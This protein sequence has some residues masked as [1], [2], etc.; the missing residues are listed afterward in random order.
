M[1]PDAFYQASRINGRVGITA[2][3]DEKSEETKAAFFT[4][5]DWMYTESKAR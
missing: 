3:L 4:F 1:E 2:A 5:L